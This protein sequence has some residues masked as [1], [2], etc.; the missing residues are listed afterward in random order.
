MAYKIRKVS[1]KQASKLNVYLKLRASYLTAHSYCQAKTDN[2][3]YNSTEIHHRRGRIG[4]DLTD[5]NYFLAVCRNCHNWI[6]DNPKEA[7]ELG[8][9]VSR[10][11]I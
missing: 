11:S 6:E 2:C 4:N 3:S 5:V 9:S 7:K 8:F 10:L 1:K